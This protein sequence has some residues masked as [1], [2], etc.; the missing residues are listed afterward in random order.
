MSRVK[1]LAFS[2]ALALAGAWVAYPGNA[3]AQA[4][5]VKDFSCKSPFSV[6]VDVAGLGTKNL[7]VTG[8]ATVD[9]SCA[10]V[11]G[12]GNCPSDAKKQTVVPARHSS[13]RTAG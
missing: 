10:C 9:L 12:G 1:F 8:S 2:A 7:C 11:G 3:W 6:N 13:R 5:N 4:F